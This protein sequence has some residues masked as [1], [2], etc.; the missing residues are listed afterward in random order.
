[1]SW[2]WKLSKLST[3]CLSM[4]KIIDPK[5]WLCLEFLHIGIIKLFFRGFFNNTHEF[6]YYFRQPLV[7]FA[8]LLTKKLSLLICAHVEDNSNYQYLDVLK[9]NVQLWLKDHNI[10][11]FFRYRLPCK[12]FLY[13]GVLGGQNAVEKRGN[14]LAVTFL[15][16]RILAAFQNK[17]KQENFQM[18]LFKI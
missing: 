14:A 3:I 9:T 17:T 18:S 13:S 12:R 8:N 2:L 6:I 10:K 15:E 7:D 16:L 1:M 5:Y 4:W 11:A